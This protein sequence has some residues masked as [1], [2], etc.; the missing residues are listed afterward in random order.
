MEKSI[1]ALRQTTVRAEAKTKSN[2]KARTKE[3]LELINELNELR[4]AK[5]DLESALE[6]ET[7][8]LQKLALDKTRLSRDIS[9]KK[10]SS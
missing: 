2:I 9:T 8:K 4:K 1:G 7:L 5:I 6:A 3:N 10:H